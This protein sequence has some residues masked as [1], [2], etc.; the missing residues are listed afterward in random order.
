M[1]GWDMFMLWTSTY[2]AVGLIIVAAERKICAR[3]DALR[4]EI[5]ASR[6]SSSGTGDVQEVLNRL[7]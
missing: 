5:R 6:P 3:I 1:S 7:C 2:V 4:A